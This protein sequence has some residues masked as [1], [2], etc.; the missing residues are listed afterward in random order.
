QEGQAREGSGRAVDGRAD[1]SDVAARR[2]DL[3]RRVPAP[4]VRG[5]GRRAST[6]GREAQAA[7]RA[8]SRAVRTR[9]VGVVAAAFV[10]VAVAARADGKPFVRS[11]LKPQSV[12]VGQPVTLDVTVFVP[13]YFT[14]APRFPQL[15]VKDAVVVFVEQGANLSERVG[16][17]SYAGQSRSYLIYPQ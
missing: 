3:T 13:S 11:T 10:S 12:T 5:A 8:G 7:R 4:Q 17:D 2:P 6:V 14:G 1:R 9:G 16:A 15:E